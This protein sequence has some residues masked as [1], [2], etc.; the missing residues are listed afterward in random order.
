VRPPELLKANEAMR[1][2]ATAMGDFSLPDGLA[3]S[4]RAVYSA[5]ANLDAASQI[6]R[7]RIQADNRLYVPGWLI[8]RYGAPEAEPTR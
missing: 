1:V 6:A 8:E 3:D 4:A 7:M 5:A 2:A